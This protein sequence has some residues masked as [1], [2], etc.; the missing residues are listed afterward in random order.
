MKAKY[1]NLLYNIG[2]IGAGIAATAL[3]GGVGGAALLAAGSTAGLE[4]WRRRNV[5]KKRIKDYSTKD[6]VTLGTEAAIAGTGAGLAK[7]ASIAKAASAANTAKAGQT[8]GQ[9]TGQTTKVTEVA[10]TSNSVNSTGLAGATNTETT[11]TRVFKYAGKSYNA[12]RPPLFNDP[13][14]GIKTVDASKKG[15][16]R[17]L[18]NQVDA[19]KIVSDATKSVAQQQ[20]NAN[21]NGVTNMTSVIDEGTNTNFNMGKQVT[22]AIKQLKELE[23]KYK[24]AVKNIEA[25]DVVNYGTQVA[26]LYANMRAINNINKLEPPKIDNVPVSPVK[27]VESDYGALERS[28]RDDL[29]SALAIKSRMDQDAGVNDSNTAAAIALSQMNKINAALSQQKTQEAMANANNELQTNLSNAQM[30][31][32]ALATGEQLRTQFDAMRGQLESQAVTNMLNIPANLMDAYLV[33]NKNMQERLDNLIKL[34]QEVTNK[35][36]LETI[37]KQIDELMMKLGYTK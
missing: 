25:K 32:Q 9:T 29:E 36:D 33:S 2:K 6:F 30:A 21:P 28:M 26:N 34:K 24:R 1:R 3:T 12:E 10:N 14:S 35:N 8:V 13:S 31:N 16:I 15:V 4:M 22:D 27:K 20:G 11:T 23:Q 19:D 37:Q 18:I 7:S 5:E 17:N